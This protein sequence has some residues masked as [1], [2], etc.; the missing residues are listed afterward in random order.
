MSRNPLI[1]YTGLP[2]FSEIRPE[3]VQPAVE[4]LIAA[5]RAKI[6]TVLARG[7][8]SWNGLVATL[9]DEDERL[10]KAFGPVGHLNGVAQNPAL[11]DAYNACLPLLS[12]YSTEVGQNEKLYAAYQALRD[13]AEYDTLMDT[14]WAAVKL[15]LTGYIIPFMFVFAPS[16]LLMGEP[17]RVALAVVTATIGVICLAG[18]LHS[19]F[20]FGPARSWERVM[21]IVAA[22]VL[23]KPGWMT[24]LVGLALIGL[25]AASQHWIR[26]A[27]KPREST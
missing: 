8:F 22:L 4:Q 14:S 23:I 7:D 16:L 2:P 21:L 10:G 25:T 26:P 15:G 20:F 12:E 17:A 9:D 19:Y 5:G 3:H 18:G 24:D 1:D 13:S 27:A 6:E 11:R